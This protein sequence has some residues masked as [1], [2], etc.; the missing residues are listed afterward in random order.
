MARRQLA[1]LCFPNGNTVVFEGDQQVPELQQPWIL[2]VAER[3]AACGRD[4]TTARW[5]LPGAREARVFKKPDGSG[6]NWE[7]V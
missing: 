1:V 2:A 7:F 5:T 4:P 6:F 3:I